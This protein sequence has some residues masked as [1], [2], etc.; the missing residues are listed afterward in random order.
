MGIWVDGDVEKQLKRLH[1]MGMTTSTIATAVGRS[2]EWVRQA[3]RLCGLETER[4]RAHRENKELRGG[5]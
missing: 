3:L 5:K 2:R 4:M 1:G